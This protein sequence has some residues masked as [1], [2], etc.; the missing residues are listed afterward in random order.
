MKALVCELHLCL[1]I[2]KI[3]SFNV[4][5]NSGINTT[6][7]SKLFELECTD[8]VVRGNE[9]PGRIKHL[10]VLSKRQR[11]QCGMHLHP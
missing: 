6:T 5:I 10:L 4:R 2:C 11:S 7:G 8:A 1:S 9:N 3:R